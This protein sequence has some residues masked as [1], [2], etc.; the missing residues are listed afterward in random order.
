VPVP[1]AV[2]QVQGHRKLQEDQPLVWEGFVP[3]LL[4]V[5]PGIAFLSHWAEDWQQ[6]KEYPETTPYHGTFYEAM[7][8]TIADQSYLGVV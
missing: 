6:K 7:L 4:E 5:D 2:R 3:S 1:V 8:S